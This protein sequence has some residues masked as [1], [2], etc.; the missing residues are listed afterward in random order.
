MMEDHKQSYCV[1]TPAYN[2]Q[3]HLQATIDS[4]VA[5]QYLPALW[6]IVDDGS[7]DG[8]W[9]IIEKAAEQH[10]WIEGYRREHK[11]N[12][13]EDGL[14][15]ASE[16]QAFLDGYEL[17][18]SRFPDS[19]YI[20]K[21]DADLKFE[22]DY[23]AALIEQFRTDPQLGIA[24][25]VIYE[26]RNGHLVKEKVSEDHVRGAT[27]IYRRTCYRDIGG[28]PPLF[29]WDVVDEMAARARGW[30]VRSFDEATL[31]HLRP[32]ASRGGRF[33]GWSR[34]GYMAYYIGISPLRMLMR[35]LYRLFA[36]GDMVQAGGLTYG[37]FS[38]FLKFAPKLPD[39]ELRHLVRDHEWVTARS[40]L[41]KRFKKKG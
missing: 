12:P 19:E 17:A 6:I 24:G 15:L 21:L 18:E 33:K 23:F 4:M 32:T 30:H 14:V 25:G 8:T 39:P 7:E 34:N 37:Y 20:V 35:S 16:A 11:R 36:A 29:G 27:K 2:E 5:Q 13:A 3:D 28:M 40:S 31:I 41:P 22:P 26:Q 10:A 1:V 38:H 9:S